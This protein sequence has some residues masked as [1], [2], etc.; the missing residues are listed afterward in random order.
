M[1]RPPVKRAKLNLPNQ[2]T[3]RVA[4][5]PLSSSP[6]ARRRELQE[7]LA[8]KPIGRV[9]ND[10]DDS[11]QLV[12]KSRNP[13]NGRGVPRREIYASG[14]L[15]QGD[16]AAAHNSPT[17]KRRRLST[18]QQHQATAQSNAIRKNGLSQPNRLRPID[19]ISTSQA[20][21]SVSGLPTSARPSPL[22]PRSSNPPRIRTQ[23]TPGAEASILGPIR[24]RKRQP[25]ILQL[26]DGPDSSILDQDLDEF[27]PNDESTPMNASRKRKLSSQPTSPGATA[28][29]Q[30]QPTRDV[31]ETDDKSQ[32]K[33]DPQLPP[34]PSNTHPRKRQSPSE[35]GDTLAPPRSSSSAPSPVKAKEPSP[36]KTK[37]R[38]RKPKEPKV[39]STTALQ[40]LMPTRRQ[41]RTRRERNAKPISE[42]EIPE[43][44]S[45]G[46]NDVTGREEHDQ[47][48]E[49]S[50]NASS[51]AANKSRKQQ[52]GGKL[53][54]KKQPA[55]S[56]QSTRSNHVRIP[57]RGSSKSIRSTQSPSLMR[58]TPLS[59][60][61]KFATK[62]SSQQ[63]NSKSATRKVYSRNGKCGHGEHGG[64]DKENRP[65]ILS[66]KPLER[67]SIA[68][69]ESSDEDLEVEVG[70]GYHGTTSTSEDEATKE[71][72]RLVRKFEEVD[73]WEMEFEDVTMDSAEA[74]DPLAR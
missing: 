58:T 54:K 33:F 10:S 47:V 70:R 45:D 28:N 1:P 13:R 5:T 16:K 7:Q 6:A 52:P 30:Q 34:A 60:S 12:T 56:K 61:T 46:P 11:D 74:S 49:D 27:L 55:S 39:L 17:N 43:D 20:R 50:Y 2:S 66:G 14:G 48:G 8:H 26:I 24:P 15:G 25:S 51:K 53:Q 9:P 23:G 19:R 32:E 36:I 37:T 63:E 73:E 21:P 59:S 31:D 57:K 64:E 40:A 67:G 38:T 18:K 71:Q 44:S 69:D 62:T 29:S 22:G 65:S 4:N 68:A 35:E 42:F 3:K 41:P 72:K